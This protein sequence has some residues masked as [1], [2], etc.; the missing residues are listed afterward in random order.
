MGSERT[1]E[2]NVCFNELVE[3]IHYE[4][5]KETY[6]GFKSRVCT[7]YKFDVT[8]TTSTYKSGSAFDA[9]L[10][11][12]KFLQGSSSCKGW[13]VTRRR[14]RGN[15]RSTVWFNIFSY[16]GQSC[17]SD[18]NLF[19]L[20]PLESMEG[21]STGVD[22]L[23]QGTLS[24]T[25]SMPWGSSWLPMSCGPARSSGTLSPTPSIP[26]GHQ[27]LR[28]KGDVARSTDVLKVPQLRDMVSF[29]RISSLW[30][31]RSDDICHTIRH[32]HDLEIILLL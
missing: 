29:P 13:W 9:E 11:F 23:G 15:S 30:W 10:L 26:R 28:E 19:L 7:T 4:T 16:E 3:A 27:P 8:T 22:L 20:S 32:S 31:L 21:L 25:S 24:P 14:W 18:K 17:D 6:Q 5:L 12:K 2:T 1:I